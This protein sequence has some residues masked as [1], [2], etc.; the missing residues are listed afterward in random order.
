MT[1]HYLPA[2]TPAE[3]EDKPV[4]DDLPLLFRTGPLEP[5][6]EAEEREPWQG[7]AEALAEAAAAGRRAADW[8][9][10]LPLAAGAWI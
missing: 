3:P 1:L 2:A 8:I 7:E 10:S 5:V 6:A 4:S 9:R